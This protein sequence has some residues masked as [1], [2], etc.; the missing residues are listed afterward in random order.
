LNRV[1]QRHITIITGLSGSGKSTALNTLEDL[2]F[3]SIDNLPTLLL[4]KLLEFYDHLG[5][6]GKPIALVM[7]LRE[8]DFMGHF[9]QTYQDLKTKGYPLELI[10]LEAS[11]EV[12]L[13]RYSQT[14]RIHPLGQESLLREA[15]QKE[16]AE[17]A[18]L[19]A[20]A[21]R[22]LDTSGLTVH[23][24]RAQME[25][26][27]A[28]EG[29]HRSMQVNLISFGYKYGLPTEADL[30]LDVRFFPNPYFI[31]EMKELDGNDP[32]VEA[33]L[34][35]WK[36]LEPFLEKTLDLLGFL[37]PHYQKE[38]KS[39]LNLAVGCTGGRHRSVVIANLLAQHL[40]RMGYPL[41]LHHRDMDHA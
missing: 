1:T 11:E 23:Q 18:P 10:F 14:R 24:L 33:F 4:P 41:T 16:K 37:F 6:E 8:K 35:E 32:R 9:P 38:G 29:L 5:E 2:G 22:I 34:L 3:L 27:Y 17:L 28:A 25:G 20:V 31:P 26:F 7:D 40:K 21:D 12:L 13:R 30:V 19:R 36:P 39:F 15:V